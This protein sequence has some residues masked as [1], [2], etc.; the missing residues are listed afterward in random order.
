M[1]IPKGGGQHPYLSSPP[2]LPSIPD[3]NT[4]LAAYLR[5]F[6]LWCQGNFNSAIQKRSATGEMY[7][8]ST[9]G[10]TVW[11]LT[12][13]DTGRLMTT[14]LIPGKPEGGPILRSASPSDKV[15]TFAP[16][17]QSVKS[18]AYNPAGTTSATYVM[19]GMAL[20]LTP[21]VATGGWITADGQITNS[22]NN[23]ETD[24]VICYGT[25][26]APANGDAQTGTIITQPA[27]YKST[28]AGDFTPFSLTSVVSGLTAGTP[29]WF[30]LAVRAVNGGTAQVMDMD[31]SVLGLA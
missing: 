10:N 21:V 6:S 28:A 11:A 17:T 25:G 3:L 5:T 23:S 19:M 18:A 30:D 26:A 24:A 31:F 9:T 12:A 22:S 1:A 16:V 7:I 14:Q 4:R 29:Y 27:R 8:K 20:V 15:N 2:D 13:D